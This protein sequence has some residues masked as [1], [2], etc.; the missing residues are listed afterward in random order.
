MRVRQREKAY[1][2]A[3]LKE[4]M[5][6]YKSRNAYMADRG[7]S[8]LRR[9]LGDIIQATRWDNAPEGRHFYPRHFPIDPS[10]MVPAANEAGQLA[11]QR[12]KLL[13]EI[14]AK[15]ESMQKLRDREPEKRWQANYDLMLAQIVTYQI[16]SY[17]Y[18]ACLEEMVTKP[19]RPKVMPS[20]DLVV[21][22]EMNH[23]RDRKAAKEKTEK[24]YVEATQLLKDVIARHPK[25]PWADL[26]QDELNR[27]FGVRRNEWHHN[28]K[29]AER[30]KLV[31]KY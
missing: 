2:I 17:E 15:L 26:A 18:R 28:P 6:D 23:S 30:A 16:K 9:T 4:Y 31:P 5:P 25:T 12:L 24:K 19:P 7:N 11:T 20:A 1:R 29:Y 10:L 8:A 22:W 3:D 14:Q 13:L 27:G 21:E